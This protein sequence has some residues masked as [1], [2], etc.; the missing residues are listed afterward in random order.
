LYDLPPATPT[1]DLNMFTH[2]TTQRVRYA[3]TDQMGVVYYGHYAQYFEVGRAEAIRHL[4][5][6]YREIEEAGVLMPVTELQVTYIRPARYDDLL[7]IRTILPEMPDARILFQHE[8]R[9]EAGKLLASGKVQL[10]FVDRD[11][12]RST[13]APALITRLLQPCFE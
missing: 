4:G 8:I 1:A 13:R 12:L 2:E 6:T 11:T 9:N 3:E 5:L 7:S 10:A